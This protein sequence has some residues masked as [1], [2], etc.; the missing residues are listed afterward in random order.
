MQLLTACR[1]G[2]ESGAQLVALWAC[3][4]RDRDRGF[5][6]NVVL[7]DNDGF[8][9]LEYAMPRED[10]AYPD[11]AAVFPAANRMQ[12]AA[13]DLV[14]IAA[15]ADDQRPWVWQASWPIDRYPLRRDF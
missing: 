8:T 12:R 2:W 7:Q 15:Q 14:G 6:L 1:V 4:D 9:L 3:D 13:F 11:L 10:S 5:T